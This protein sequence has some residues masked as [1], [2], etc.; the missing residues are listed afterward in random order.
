[1]VDPLNAS[2][3]ARFHTYSAEEIKA[4]GDRFAVDE[5][6]DGRTDYSFASP[7]FN[8]V[9]FRSNLVL[10]WEYRPGSELYLVWSQGSTPDVARDL[11]TPIQE[12]LFTNLFNQQ[13]RNIGLV[14]FTYR[15]LK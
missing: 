12:S 10:R 5:N 6:G 2:Y 11:E 14:K 13:S 3:D 8:F 4:V 7:D 9:Q 15:F 1:V